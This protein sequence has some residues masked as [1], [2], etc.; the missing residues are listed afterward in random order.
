MSILLRISPAAGSATFG[1][2]Y[3]AE[4]ERHQPEDA[5]TAYFNSVG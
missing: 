4:D 1:Y 5:I 3:I 2:I